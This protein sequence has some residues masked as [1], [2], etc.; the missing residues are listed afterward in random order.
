ML[1]SFVFNCPGNDCCARQCV[2]SSTLGVETTL[3]PTIRAVTNQ[4]NSYATLCTGAVARES[5]L[6]PTICVET[7]L[8]NIC[9]ILFMR[10]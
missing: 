9:E 7:R 6:M 2:L 10:T 1:R 3:M 4:S 8:T 5:M